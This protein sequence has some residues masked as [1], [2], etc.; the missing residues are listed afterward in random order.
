MFLFHLNS[1]PSVSF[2]FIIARNGKIK[3]NS[4]IA[5]KTGLAAR[6]KTER[7]GSQNT[8]QKELTRMQKFL[9]SAG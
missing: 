8:A 2:S 5:S 7:H 1:S 4:L 6:E 3:P 9:K